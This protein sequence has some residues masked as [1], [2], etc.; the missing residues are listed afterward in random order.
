MNQHLHPSNIVG[1]R[2]GRAFDP[3]FT[4]PPTTHE[5]RAYDAASR[6]LK[7]TELEMG[8]CKFPVNVGAPHRFCGCSAG[9]G[10]PYCDHH[11][12]RASGGYWQPGRA[13]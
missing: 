2:E 13:E 9:P 1:K 7:L 10:K 8:D 11:A 5:K 12:A 4:P 3:G 6:H